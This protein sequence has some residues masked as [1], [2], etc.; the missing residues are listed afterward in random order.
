[1]IQKI[2]EE[3]ERL[4]GQL[5]RG[6]CAAQI[7]MKTNCKEE[8]YNEILSFLDTLEKSENQKNNGTCKIIGKSLDDFIVNGK[9]IVCNDPPIDD[10]PQF[11]L[12]L[13]N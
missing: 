2:R 7:E 9:E 8:A 3:I 11:N 12:D 6:A 1:M 10:G 4:K 5:V 13:S